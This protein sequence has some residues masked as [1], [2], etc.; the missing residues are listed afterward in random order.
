M[1]PRT[2]LLLLAAAIVLACFIAFVERRS[3]STRQREE[4]A[5]RALQIRTDHVSYL[6]FQS[7]N[8]V[9]ECAKDDDSWVVVQPF[10]A[11]ADAAVI[12]R[13][14]AGL[15]ELPRGEVITA[16]EQKAR[17]LTAAQ[18][19]LDAPRVKITLGD[20]L[21]RQTIL[22]GREA[23]LGGAL[24][25]REEGRE[26][27]V[28]TS[29]NLLALIPAGVETVRDRTLFPGTAQGVQRLEI[30]GPGG[31]IQAARMDR[32]RWMLQQPLVG[33]ASPTAVQELLDALFDLRVEE[34][35]TESAA[36]LAR[37]GLDEPA[38]RVTLWSGE[39]EGEAVLLLGDVAEGAGLVYAKLKSGDSIYGVG[40]NVLGRVRVPAADLRDRRLL[41][42]SAYDISYLRA[43]EGEQA[44]VLQKAEGGWELVEPKPWK[45]DDQRVRDL[46]SAWAN[47]KIE[48]F[49]DDAG[50]NLA[51]AGLSPPAR[52]LRFSCRKQ[53][54]AG[55]GRP[56]VGSEEDAAVLVSRN[57]REMGRALVKVE[58][59][60]ALYEIL[61]DPVRMVSLDPLHYRDREVLNLSADAIVKI[62]VRQD[63][64]EQVVER[65]TADAFIAPAGGTNRVNQEVVKDLLTAASRLRAARYVADDPA[66]LAPFGLDAPR[67]LV[68]LGLKGESGISRS[69]L[70]GAAAEEGGVYAM[71]RGQ[72]V[73]F[74]LDESARAKLL[75]DL[76]GVAV[77]AGEPP[78]GR[79]TNEPVRPA[80]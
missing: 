63:G 54:A 72:D 15:Q 70:V 73:V 43:E 55:G 22:V 11:R 61:S 51:A 35:V 31:L 10:R 58:A 66:D 79:S 65:G 2:T 19:G 41:T 67:A 40:T 5:R 42:M 68:T 24:Y 78:A 8:L 12:D 3:E 32:G 34:F 6:R 21:R 50:T 30:S 1:R 64:R 33:R 45:A 13:I 27:I 57:A 38:F 28:A 17:G 4:E 62:T 44:V 20:S 36:D 16:K 29:T 56:V 9:I 71:L 18:Y 76:F 74:V 26:D 53:P 39:K 75:G 25:L 80:R 47:A 14:L 77:R 7:T 52:I 59:E 69:L 23:L 49:V 48:A 60:P 37:Y 46:V